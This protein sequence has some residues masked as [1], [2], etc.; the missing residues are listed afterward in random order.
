M[1]FDNISSVCV[2]VFVF[3]CLSVCVCLCV[4]VFEC[5]CVCVCMYVC[6]C[7]CVCVCEI[8]DRKVLTWALGGAH[9]KRTTWRQ[10]VKIEIGVPQ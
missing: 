7:V 9:K 1:F 5:V 6:V 3:V 8:S 2:C 10:S 4:C